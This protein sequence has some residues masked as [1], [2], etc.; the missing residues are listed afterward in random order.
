MGQHHSQTLNYIGQ[1]EIVLKATEN[2]KESVDSLSWKTGEKLEISSDTRA[3]QDATQCRIPAEDR[4]Q[5]NYKT[6][7][8]ASKPQ[9]TKKRYQKSLTY[10][11]QN[12]SHCENWGHSFYAFSKIWC[13][14][15]LKDWDE[16][17]L[18]GSVNLN[19]FSGPFVGPKVC[20]CV[21]VLLLSVFLTLFCFVNVN[22]AEFLTLYIL[23][24]EGD[25]SLTTAQ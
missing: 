23:Y 18:I 24:L 25:I 2:L 10:S 21:C 15:F 17:Q 1:R 9:R 11:N 12:H 3:V 22:F 20:F 19:Y 13:H 5:S 14:L 16:V 4:A 7:H 6:L 8:V